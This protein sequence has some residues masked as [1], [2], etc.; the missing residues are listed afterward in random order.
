[1][2]KKPDHKAITI[3]SIPAAKNKDLEEVFPIRLLRGYDIGWDANRWRL[4]LLVAKGTSRNPSQRLA[5][6]YGVGA[7]T[8]EPYLTAATFGDML[9][10]LGRRLHKLHKRGR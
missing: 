7:S 5:K 3:L 10:A 6:Q 8:S 1:M 4:D 2:K 9:I